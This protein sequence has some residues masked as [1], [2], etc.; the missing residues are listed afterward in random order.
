MSP[1]ELLY[2]RTRFEVLRAIHSSPPVPLREIAYRADVVV[3]N[4]QRA[5]KYLLKRKFI[6]VKKIDN[7]ICYQISNQKIEE[8]VSS[9]IKVLEPF[10]IENRSKDVTERSSRLVKI[11]DERS[12]LIR[13]AKGSLKA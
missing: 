12:N 4:V 6:S 7:R 5:I 1:Q 9:I 10:E 2:P 13:R 3:S 11:L 8:L